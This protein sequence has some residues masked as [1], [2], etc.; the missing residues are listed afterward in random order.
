MLTKT[1]RLLSMLVLAIS[2]TTNVHASL[3]TFDFE[4]AS[5]G[6]NFTNYYSQ[7]FRFSPNSHWDAVPGPTGVWLGWDHA[8]VP[9]SPPHIESN[10]DW[11]GPAE[12]SAVT[13]GGT[14]VPSL[15]Y[16]D[17]V[18]RDFSLLSTDVLGGESL[19]FRSSKGGALTTGVTHLTAVN[20]EFTGDEW[21]DIDWL[22]ITGGGGIPYGID[23]L[24]IGTIPEPAT[25][26][27]VCMGLIGV[28]AR[29]R[30]G[31]RRRDDSGDQV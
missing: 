1:T 4:D 13:N 14:P 12:L 23:N 29:R 8:S 20:F 21:R 17:F 3:V 11:L 6:V 28:V 30:R 26:A 7:G 2:S 31:Q 24:V 15:M 5:G 18:G 16:V 22:L 27:L 19:T 25:A 10:P 9:N